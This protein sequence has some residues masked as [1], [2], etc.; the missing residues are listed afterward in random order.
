MARDLESAVDTVMRDLADARI[1]KLVVANR[2]RWMQQAP[3][4]A[5]SPTAAAANDGARALR[6][7]RSNLVSLRCLQ[8]AQFRPRNGEICP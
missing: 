3:G 5:E 4:A 2:I 8:P 7:A 1:A 6:T